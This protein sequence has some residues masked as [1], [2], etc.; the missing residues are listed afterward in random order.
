MAAAAPSPPSTPSPDP[1][2]PA[3]R[4][5]LTRGHPAS[6]VSGQAWPWGAQPAG[7]PG[8]CH[9]WAPRPGADPSRS[10]FRL[11][12]TEDVNWLYVQL[13]RARQDTRLYAVVG[14]EPQ[15]ASGSR[16][17]PT[18]SSRMPLQ[19]AQAL[20]RA[21]G[22]D[23]GRRHPQQP[24][25]PAAVHKGPAGRGGPAPP[26]ARPGPR[27]RTRELVRAAATVSKL[28]AL[29]AHQQPHRSPAHGDLWLAS[30]PTINLAAYRVG[31]E[32]ATPTGQPG[33]RPRA[34]AAPA[35]AAPRR[36]ARGQRASRPAVSAGGADPGLAAARHRP[37]RRSRPPRAMSWRRWVRCRRRPGAGGPGARPPPKSSRTGA[38]T[39]SP[40][41]TGPDRPA[42]PAQRADRQPARAAIG[43]GSGQRRR[44]RPPHDAQPTSEHPTQPQA[45]QQ[46]IATEAPRHLF[47]NS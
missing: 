11:T 12:G 22:P 47:L 26:P 44:R 40:T 36:L 6:A 37:G 43:Q 30:P 32:M 27:D 24:R 16:T 31:R 18:G 20:S 14:P 1:D 38:P 23:P 35:P 4:R 10:W 9:H 46:P 2:H 21:Q 8:L 41:R 17:C 33:P 29:A 39:R 25:P 7:G 5:R 19:L 45:H 13:S 3:G 15:G 28:E 34:G 42:D